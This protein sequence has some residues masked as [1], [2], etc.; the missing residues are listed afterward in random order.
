MLGQV[1]S[2]LRGFVSYPNAHA[3]LSFLSIVVD[4]D[5]EEVIGRHR[6]LKV[7]AQPF[8][9]PV[10]AMVPAVPVSQVVAVQVVLLFPVISA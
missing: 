4:V 5:A 10:A 6:H 3:K 2:F 9:A 1:A 8:G 7:I